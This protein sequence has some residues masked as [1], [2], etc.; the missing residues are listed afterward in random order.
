M[1]GGG[2]GWTKGL[3]IISL[4]F[5]LIGVTGALSALMGFAML[6]ITPM[7]SDTTGMSHSRKQIVEEFED[8][9][10]AARQKYLPVLIYMQVMKLGLAVGFLVS[11][12]M[13]LQRK[14]RGR[15]LAVA[16][17]CLALL[18][19]FSNLGV[20]LLVANDGGSL[21][22]FMSKA[23]D[24]AASQQDLTAEQRAEGE[25]FIKNA[26]FAGALI[27]MSVA[28]LIKIVFYGCIILHLIQPEVR[29]IFG[30]DPVAESAEKN[31]VPVPA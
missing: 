21:T 14:A 8:A 24:D 4:F 16:T 7:R 11:V 19:H 27:G 22:G 30:E 12:V 23:V 18:F 17:C 28:L 10:I 31:G 1:P 3:W 2:S 15:S 20:G 26:V 6:F 5:V 13:M 9:Q 29:R 25:A